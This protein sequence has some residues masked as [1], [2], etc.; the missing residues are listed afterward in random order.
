MPNWRQEYLSSFKDVELSNPVN[1]ELVQTCSQMADRI[2][3]LEAEKAALEAS[4][5]APTAQKQTAPAALSSDDPGV[6]QLRLDL[7]E[8]LRSKGVTETRLRTAE[9][10]LDKLRAKT[11]EDSRALRA[12]D[13][14]RAK[15]RTSLKDREYEIQERRKLL[16]NVQDEVIAL[17]IQ[18]SIAEKE[19]DKVRKENKELVD[20]W[21][22][23]MA[24]E[25]DAMNL[26]NEHNS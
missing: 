11:K 22:R 7:A 14:E 17:N 8:A 2:S 18:L 13:A 12:L 10:E 1:M 6:A 25:A 16:E 26:H 19:R 9:E 3:A 4:L 21:M 20:R 5:P 24:Q 23:R 15:L